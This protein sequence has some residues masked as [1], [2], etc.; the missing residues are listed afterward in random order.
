M[1]IADLSI[2]GN[3]RDAM[4]AFIARMKDQEGSLFRDGLHIPDNNGEV[5]FGEQDEDGDLKV[6]M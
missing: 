2:G 1:W 4:L 6:F 5:N 3:P